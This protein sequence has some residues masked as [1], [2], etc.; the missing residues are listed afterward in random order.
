M[1]AVPTDKSMDPFG[2]DSLDERICDFLVEHGRLKETDL[3]RARRLHEENAEGNLV[4]LL[5]RLGLVSERDMGEALAELLH[6]PLIT[7]KE[8]PEAPPQT[9]AMSVRFLKQYHVVPIAEDEK[10]VT[11]LV[12]DPANEY[13]R[14]A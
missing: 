1:V 6:L 4:P 7:A 5:T 10:S 9:S 3:V 14:Q 11:L 8:C 12:G 13:P 2:S